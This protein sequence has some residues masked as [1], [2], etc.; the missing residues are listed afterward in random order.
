MTTP[1]R[2]LRPRLSHLKMA[3]LLALGAGLA[4]TLSAARPLDG[5][6]IHGKVQFDKHCVKCH[7]KGGRGGSAIKLTDGGR[8]NGL[9]DQ[10]LLK[11]LRGGVQ[12]AGKHKGIKKDFALLDAWDLVGYLRSHVPHVGELFPA[13]DRYIV[14]EYQINKY[15]LDRLRKS[16]DR[17]LPAKK[18][19]GRVFTMFDIGSKTQL[20]LVPQNPR[21]LDGLKRRMKVGYVVFMPFEKPG[22]GV[23]ELAVALEPKLMAVAKLIAVDT[24]GKEDRDL[25]KLLSRFTGKGDRRLSGKPKARLAAGG[26]GKQLRALEAKVT[27]SFLRAAELATAYEVEERERS[28]A[29]DDIELPDPTE[30][31]ADE[32]SIK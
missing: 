28:W 22:G 30:K 29:D 17:E 31:D 3:G 6:P 12:G 27:E 7:G 4:L 32:F 23:V 9:S 20:E 10:G 25:N 2:A 16:L 14:K 8:I 11:L 13:A 21:L 26:G 24:A 1:I 5:D 18:A 19:K 15:G